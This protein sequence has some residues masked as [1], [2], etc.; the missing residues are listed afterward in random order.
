MVSLSGFI[1]V[2]EEIFSIDLTILRNEV[3]ILLDMN[4]NKYKLSLFI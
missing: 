1:I 3:L 2:P 4:Q